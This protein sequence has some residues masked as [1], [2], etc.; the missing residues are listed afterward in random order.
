LLWQLEQLRSY[1]SKSLLTRAMVFTTPA[2]RSVQPD[3][4]VL[5][6]KSRI[7]CFKRLCCVT[8]VSSAVMLVLVCM[9]SGLTSPGS[10]VP[11]VRDYLMLAQTK[12]PKDI[13]QELQAN[14]EAKVEVSEEEQEQ[15]ADYYEWLTMGENS[16]CS[17]PLE[18]AADIIRDLTEEGCRSRC[19]MDED[20]CSG[21][22]FSGTP[23]K[24]K[25]TLYARHIRASQAAASFKC[26]TRVWAGAWGDEAENHACRLDRSDRSYNGQDTAIEGPK[27][28]K[29]RDC[30]NYCRSRLG[31]R[32]HGIEY[33]GSSGRC[34]M[35]TRPSTYN[36]PAD[37]YT[38]VSFK[39]KHE[40]K[41]DGSTF[42]IWSKSSTK[43]LNDELIMADC[44]Y[45]SSISL[46]RWGLT[47][48]GHIINMHHGDGCLAAAGGELAYRKCKQEMTWTLTGA[49]QLMNSKGKCIDV[50]M[51]DIGHAAAV[52]KCTVDDGQIFRLIR[53]AKPA[54]LSRVDLPGNIDTKAVCNDGSR[55]AYFFRKSTAPGMARTWLLYLK[56]GSW[57]TDKGAC[58]SRMKWAKHL[59]SS[60]PW[61][62]KESK[63]GIFGSESPLADS[64]IAY[65]PYC[66]SDGHMGDHSALGLEFR[67]YRIVRAIARHL[68]SAQ[69]LKSGD[70]LV[71]GGFS[72]GGRG[73]MVH[74]DTI[75]EVLP[76]GIKILGFLDSPMWMSMSPWHV[77]Q[78]KKAINTWVSRDLLRACGDRF[79]HAEQWKCICGEFRVPILK[80]PFLVVA[81]QYDGFGLGGNVRHDHFRERFAKETRRVLSSLPPHAAVF[82]TACFEHAVSEN[83]HFNVEGVSAG[84][85]K[86]SSTQSS[87][88]NLTLQAFNAGKDS[89]F[90]KVMETCEGL[91][92]GPGCLEAKLCKNEPHLCAAPAKKAKPWT[93]KWDVATEHA[94]C[95]L[96]K[97]D[98]TTDGQGSAI[99]GPAGETLDAC[100]ARCVTQLGGHCKGVE[101]HDSSGRCEMW[102]RPPTHT[103]TVSDFT[104]VM[105]KEAASTATVKESA[106][107][108][109][110]T[111]PGCY[112]KQPSKSAKCGGPF[113]GWS[114]DTWGERNEEAGASESKC[115]ARK[116]GHDGYCSTKTSWKFVV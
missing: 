116:K 95:R 20:K 34:E 73:A 44:E 51:G 99:F 49:G 104:C 66:S 69:G 26:V 114:R 9:G 56:G 17:V 76:S 74:L 40:V 98:T 111:Q 63:V 101:Y 42:L 33:H 15:A 52:T 5:T 85:G 112:F 46:Q 19:L 106:S 6:L 77:D 4:D 13:R 105:V 47:D 38:C 18:D 58:D 7:C 22:D 93:G 31:S 3:A 83:I 86:R 37:G 103:V 107:G 92:C 110:G 29:L 78:M 10:N 55:P 25:C 65:Y 84:N 32:C 62:S 108:A 64:N 1:R 23:G 113:L 71:I 14:E 80:N 57:C 81:S 87:M 79:S 89:G 67:G 72:A 2:Y 115:L 59:M 28:A 109:S 27:H 12:M 50:G 100:K 11:M 68:V 35:W 24:E 21:Y 60:K 39:K 70:T 97:T 96:D 75:H 102:T 8:A 48:K 82:S 91:H 16:R 88:L 36:K 43:C 53:F 41:L 30:Q 90:E 61:G 94:A 45:T 54:E